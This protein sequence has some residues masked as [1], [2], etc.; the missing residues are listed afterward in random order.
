[1]STSGGV[2][3]EPRLLPDDASGDDYSEEIH[4][5]VRAPESGGWSLTGGVEGCAKLPWDS[6]LLQWA[7]GTFSTTPQSLAGS[8]PWTSAAGAEHVQSQSSFGASHRKAA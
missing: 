5:P 3:T 1:M 6:G 8:G 2:K 7:S 4:V